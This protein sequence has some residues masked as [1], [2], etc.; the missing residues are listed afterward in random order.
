METSGS[1]PGKIWPPHEDIWQ[2]L[3]RF[4]HHSQSAFFFFFVFL[5]LHLQHMEVPRLGVKSEL[6][7][8]A[9]TTAMLDMSHTCDLHHSSWQR[10]IFNPLSRARDR[11]CVFMDTSQVRYG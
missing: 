4:C 10:R 6:Q 5:G 8:P 9:Y 11:T 7:S 3:E 2:C 1:Q